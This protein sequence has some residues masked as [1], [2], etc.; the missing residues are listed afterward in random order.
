MTRIKN[1]IIYAALG[2]CLVLAGIGVALSVP[3]SPI[4]AAALSIDDI[5]ISEDD[6]ITTWECPSCGKNTCRFYYRSQS[7]ERTGIEVS[8]CTNTS[9][10]Y[11]DVNE[12]PPTG[13]DIINEYVFAMPT[14]T[15]QPLRR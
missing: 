10:N 12:Y 2:I 4:T 13:H 14:C 1:W 15:V 5:D 11:R 6:Y 8:A 7:C 3:Q 9:C